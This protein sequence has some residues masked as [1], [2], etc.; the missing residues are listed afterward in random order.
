LAH[1]IREAMRCEPVKGMLKGDVQ[2]DET[3]VGG[4]PRRGVYRE[5]HKRGKGTDKTPVVAMV[6]TGGQVVS[7]PIATADIRTMSAIM[8]KHVDKSARILT[9]EAQFYHK[10]A[11]AFAGHE[12]INHGEGQYVRESDGLNTNTVESF[13]G[14]IKRGHY[15]VYHQMSRKH[16]HRYTDEFSFRWN[17]RK[18]CD[19]VR[20]DAA[21]DGAEGKRL[22]YRTPINQKG[23]GATH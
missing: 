20:R 11:E 5:A 3:Y 2:I 17:G 9:D 8:K 7:Q 1:R 12:R 13:F 6:E 15:G 4:K 19:V 14:L 21:V 23:D 18:L 22:Y 10:P 16:M